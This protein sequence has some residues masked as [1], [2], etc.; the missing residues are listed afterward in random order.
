MGVL[1]SGNEAVARGAYEAGVRVATAYP[2]TPSTEILQNISMW[3]KNI[4]A[5]WSPNEK[6]AFEVVTGSSMAGARSLVAMKHVGLN[7]AADPFMTFAYTGV[8]GGLIVVSAD[9]PSMHSSQNE[10]D[11]R[12]YAKF[13]MIPMLE[14]S[15]SQESKD[16]VRL[17]L[18]ISEEY[19]TP[20]M[21]RMVTRVSHSKGVVATADP[22]HA[23]VSGFKRDIS[24]YVMVPGHARIRRRVVLERLGKL[25][26]LSETVPVNVVERGSSDIGI[27]TSGISY[28]YAKEV[29]P[30]ASYLKLGMPYPLPEKKIRQFAASVRRLLIVEEL[31]PFLEEQ[32]RAMDIECDGKKYFTSY[33]ELSSM[34]VADGLAN[35]GV[36]QKRVTASHEEEPLF[37]RPPVLC[38]GCPHRG[39][40][41]VLRKLKVPVTGDIG[42]YTLAAL[43][44]L[45]SMD[46]C[47]C[48][49][50]SI[51]SAI[52][53]AKANGTK[54]SVVAAIGDSTFLHSGITG[55]LDATYNRANIT[56]V[57]L[58]NRTTAMTGG[59]HHPGT[60]T[61][62]MGE[63]TFQVDLVRLCE[64]LGVTDIQTVDPYNL[65]ESKAAFQR[66]F[67]HDGPSV[68]I[69]NRP[70][71]LMP[72]R[73]KEAP[74]K[75]ISESCNGCKLC[76]RVGCPAIAASKEITKK[77]H[78]KAIIDEDLCTGCT[79]CAQVCPEDAIVL[80]T[81]QVGS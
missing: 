10:Q 1:M 50:A 60:G 14:P 81:E 27:I 72:R 36:L 70:C 52:G 7:V 34:V 73:V 45:T 33:G 53:M 28:Q 63:E 58:D 74:Y 20:V 12:F 2:G 65:E 3:Y 41:T 77:G 46:S 13:A 66:S 17:G 31:E 9:D 42:C 8:K 21:L 22:I 18:E 69:T 35:A 38:P 80:A 4:Y 30:D 44:P 25:R 26:E 43:D 64:A 15:D 32:I 55:L 5:E 29:L 40:F 62:L 24:K 54:K 71:V 68:V 39:I 79:I 67:Q 76:F 19:D 56:V 57:I 11:N 59:Q 51:G 49:G 61:T 75:V 37:P 6:V 47:I 16:L 78:P 48:M 23:E